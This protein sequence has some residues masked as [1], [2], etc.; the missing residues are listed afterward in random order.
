M[1]ALINVSF[2]WKERS[3]LLHSRSLLLEKRPTITLDVDDECFDKRLDIHDKYLDRSVG[4]SPL[5]RVCV[6]VF[7]HVCVCVCMLIGAWACRL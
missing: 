5:T 7:M 3:L 2:A 1:N 4:M 6:G